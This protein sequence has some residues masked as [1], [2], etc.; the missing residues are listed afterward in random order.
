MEGGFGVFDSH[1]NLDTGPTT[2][3]AARE[4]AKGLNSTA[5]GATEAPTELAESEAPKVEL[6][7]V[8]EHYGPMAKDNFSHLART[9]PTEEARSYWQ[10]KADAL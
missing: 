1:G 9:A 7:T 5:E 6:P 8:T 10:A 2:R 4:F 3:D